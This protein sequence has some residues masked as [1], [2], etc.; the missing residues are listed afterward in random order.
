M[1][2]LLTTI[3]T[4]FKH[5][6][7]PV[8]T[9]V[10]VEEETGSIKQTINTGYEDENI[11]SLPQQ[12]PEENTDSVTFEESIK[13]TINTGY[14]ETEFIKF[15]PPK[16]VEEAISLDEFE[17]SIKYTIKTGYEDKGV[18]VVPSP[19]EIEEI[20]S[21]DKFEESVKESV[22]TGFGGGTLNKECPGPKL[23]EYL[24]QGNH[25]SEFRTD[26]DKLLARQN[27]G[28]YSKSE[29]QK[30]LNDITNNVG[31]LYV[32]KIEVQTMISQ[33]DFVDSVLKSYVNYEVPSNLFR[34]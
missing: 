22:D 5:D 13:Q 27:L 10:F 19:E 20:T 14:K 24:E 30:L 1:K 6:D 8:V 12:K 15:L 21:S 11:P 32:T 18:A 25:L 34:L 33:I 29:V 26:T 23:V 4:G 2:S 9:K 17:G 16:E 31:N 3:T 7:K 28:V